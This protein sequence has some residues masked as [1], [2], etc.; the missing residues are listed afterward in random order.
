MDPK[1]LDPKALD[2]KVLD[3]K[4]LVRERL[5]RLLAVWKPMN[6]VPPV[7]GVPAGG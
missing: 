4:A 2:S 3:P 1:A 7:Q 6:G 5:V